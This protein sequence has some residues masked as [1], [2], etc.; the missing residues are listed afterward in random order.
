MSATRPIEPEDL[1]EHVEWLVKLAGKLVVDKHAAEDL[2]QE[3]MVRA[4]RTRPRSDRALRPWLSTVLRNL[5][6]TRARDDGRRSVREQAN[7]RSEYSTDISEQ[8]SSTTETLGFLMSELHRLDDSF[9]TVVSLRYMRGLDSNQIAKQLGIPSGTVR[10]RLKRGLEL[11]RERLASRCGGESQADHRLMLV[12]GT[13]LEKQAAVGPMVFISAVLVAV[14]AI[15][16]L[17]S[18]ENEPA[19]RAVLSTQQPQEVEGDG[20]LQGQAFDRFGVGSHVSDRTALL[21]KPITTDRPEPHQLGP[22][23]VAVR[24]QVLSPEGAPV[25]GARFR[26]SSGRDAWTHS[27]AKGW[28]VLMLRPHGDRTRTTFSIEKGG[29][30]TRTVRADVQVGEW[31][32]LGSILMT[33][34]QTISGTVIDQAGDP[35]PNTI[36]L[37]GPEHTSQLKQEIVRTGPA[38]W[39][40]YAIQSHETDVDGRFFMTDVPD[41]PVRL[42][43]ANSDTLFAS[44]EVLAGGASDVQI[45]LEP[46]PRIDAIAGTILGKNGQ[47]AAFAFLHARPAVTPQ[48]VGGADSDNQTWRTKQPRIETDAAGNFCFVPRILAPH[49]LIAEDPEDRWQDIR[50]EGVTPGTGGLQ[51]QFLAELE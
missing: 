46:L 9:R 28:A 6:R 21:S 1:L 8:V 29:F 26:W 15:W 32:L 42:W 43:A 22:D 5:T 3:T 41:V 34:T 44:S 27:N 7:S 2:A 30:A 17:A 39:S 24:V 36:V 49:V 35:V 11:L 25:S 4:L 37:V 51:L 45:S 13:L 18:A 10:W 31:S 12:V 40:E 38:A 48:Q 23:Q 16:I 47:P 20:E 14:L 50:I 33:P 19:A